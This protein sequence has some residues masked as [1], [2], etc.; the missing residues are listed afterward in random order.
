M[1][2]IPFLP[3]KDKA[4]FNY[5]TPSRLWRSLKF[6]NTM[7]AQSNLQTNHSPDE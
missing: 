4:V 2:W 1:E 5:I 7:F 3:Q 6:R